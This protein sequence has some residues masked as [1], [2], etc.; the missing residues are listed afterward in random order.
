M[1][2]ATKDSLQGYLDTIPGKQKRHEVQT[3]AI[4][5]TVSIL[6]IT[7]N[8]NFSRL[9]KLSALLFQVKDLLYMLDSIQGR[10]LYT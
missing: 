8:S 2:G 3:A 9:L 1:V 5:G 6:K 4:R 7:L 10:L